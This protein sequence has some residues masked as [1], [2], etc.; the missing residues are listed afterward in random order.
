MKTSLS[1]ANIMTGLALFLVLAN[2]NKITPQAEAAK[3]KDKDGGECTTADV[4]LAINPKNNN[5]PTQFD[6]CASKA[7]GNAEKTSACLRKHYPALSQGCAACFGQTASC[8]ASNC[9]FKC[10]TNHFSDACLSCVDTSCRDHKKDGSFSLMECSGLA[11]DKL[12]PSKAA[13]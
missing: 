7:W 2:C 1:I 13:K 3:I 8:S 6:K 12:P 11:K 5:F 9:K 4:E 10:F